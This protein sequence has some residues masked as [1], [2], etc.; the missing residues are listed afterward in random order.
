[1]RDRLL[2]YVKADKKNEIGR[3]NCLVWISKIWDVQ[4][5]NR[6]TR[7]PYPRCSKTFFRRVITIVKLA[8]TTS[9]RIIAI[10][11]LN[12]IMINCLQNPRT[13]VLPDKWH[14]DLSQNWE[15]FTLDFGGCSRDDIA[16]KTLQALGFHIFAT[17]YFKERSP[18]FTDITDLE[19]IAEPAMIDNPGQDVTDS[20]EKVVKKK[21]KC[22]AKRQ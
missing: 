11:K 21:N 16:D 13:S 2:G 15:I 14:F 10:K 7:L 9:R 5:Q 19:L 12:N 8:P 22:T 17:G 1:M 4:Q 20:E 3:T 18:R 6:F